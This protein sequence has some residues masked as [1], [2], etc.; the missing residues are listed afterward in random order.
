MRSG[1]LVP[2]AEAFSVEDIV[3]TLE[4][5]Q[6]EPYYY[7]KVLSTQIIP[8]WLLARTRLRVRALKKVK[9]DFSRVGRFQ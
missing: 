4:I 2:P 3:H 7:E 1:R 8:K 5:E 9:F 6:R